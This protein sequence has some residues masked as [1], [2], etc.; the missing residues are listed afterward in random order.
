MKKALDAVPFTKALWPQALETLVRAFADDPVATHFFPDVSRRS[1]GMAQIFRMGLG[2]GLP[3]GEV[4]VIGD[5]GAV[6]VWIRPEYTH[7]KWFHL[8]QIGILQM[9]FTVGWNTTR[10]LLEFERFIETCRHRHLAIPHWYL[11]CIGVHP[12]HQGQGFGSA[13]LRHGLARVQAARSPCY[14]ETVNP[15]NLPFYKSQGFREVGEKQI[16]RDGPGVWSLI[17]GMDG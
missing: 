11:F 3:H 10:R 17:A 15:R 14:L 5:A 8:L 16:P 2:Y 1:A 12:D 6:A 7:V 4:D 13:L 9:P